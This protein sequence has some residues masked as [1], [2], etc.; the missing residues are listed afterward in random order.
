MHVDAYVA[1]HFDAADTGGAVLVR[2]GQSVLLNRGYGLRDRA[3]QSPNTPETIFQIASVSKQFTAAVVLLLHERGLLSLEDR[4]CTWISHCPPAWEP[5]TIHQLLSHTAGLGHWNDLAP[6]PELLYTT[7][8]R[9][10]LMRVFQAAPLHFPPGEGWSYSSLGFVLLAH[11]IELST[12]ETHATT[13]RDTIF[14]PLGMH[15]SGA[16]SGAPYPERRATGY[17]DGKPAPSFELDTVGIGTGD[18][19]STTADLAR[20]DAA[21]AT[22][23]LLTKP[24]L[25]EMFTPHAVTTSSRP[26]LST[27]HYGYGWFLSRLAG[28]RLYFHPG[29]NAGFQSFNLWLPDDAITIVVLANEDG[30]VDPGTVGLRI[31]SALLSA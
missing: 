22:P 11:I 18:I 17:S 7:T 6:D 3:R 12:G 23:G 25:R 30:R 15:S 1:E 4:L 10:D 24:S 21:L 16:G 2:Q 27:I 28:H 19:W 20:W 31:A 13:L 26:E 14:Q 9:N 5:I 8:A 29:D